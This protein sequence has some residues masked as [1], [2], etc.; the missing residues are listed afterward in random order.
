MRGPVRWALDTALSTQ[1]RASTAT[2]KIRCPI[3]QY[4]AGKPDRSEST[5]GSVPAGQSRALLWRHLRALRH[6]CQDRP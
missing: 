2:K 4:W 1:G 6:V 5:K 3:G